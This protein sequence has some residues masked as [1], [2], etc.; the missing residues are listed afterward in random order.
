MK[1]VEGVDVPVEGKGTVRIT[2]RVNGCT[3]T[4]ILNN[5][6]YVPQ[7]PN[8]LFSV[9]H[10]DENGGHTKMGSGIA[11]LYDKEKNKIAIGHKVKRMYLLDREM[12]HKE[13][14]NVTKETFNTSWEEW[15]K[16]FGHIDMSRLQHMNKGG[17]VDGF[18]APKDEPT[19]ECVACTK[20]KQTRNPFPRKQIMRTT[21]PGELIHTDL[22]EAHET[23]IHG[24]KY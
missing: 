1:G 16:R 2:S 18:E 8:N 9:T 19:F 7:A 22:W 12:L 13:R 6:L 4:M 17:L 5:V 21:Q 11:E 24:V 23:G 20:V 10:L 3:R 14:G 15:H